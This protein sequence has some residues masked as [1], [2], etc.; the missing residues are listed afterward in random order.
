M[1][2]RLSQLLRELLIQHPTDSYLRQ[3]ES[4]IRGNLYLLRRHHQ[5]YERALGSLDEAS[6]E[7][8]RHK[9]MRSFVAGTSRRGKQALFDQLN[10][11]FAY[12]H[13]VNKGY[14]EVAFVPEQQREGLKTPDLTFLRGAERRYCEV[15]TINR[16]DAQIVR[17]DSKDV[18]DTSLLYSELGQGFERKLTDDIAKAIAQLR[19]RCWNGMVYVLVQS[20]DW[21][22]NSLSAHVAQVRE[23]LRRH[24]PAVEVCVKFEVSGRNQLT[25]HPVVGPKP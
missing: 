19:S 16:S 13:L 22:L 17:D 23:I 7:T 8:L 20:D 15:K 10:E 25:Y 3:H 4:K 21:A 11:A 9:A 2:G 24:A 6:W 1:M 5:P 18:F 14:K 12:R